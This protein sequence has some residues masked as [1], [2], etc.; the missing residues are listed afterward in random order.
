MCECFSGKYKELEACKEEAA[1]GSELARLDARL[2][3]LEA[4]KKAAVEAGDYEAA[5]RHQAGIRWV[6]EQRQALVASDERA[7]RLE[8]RIQDLRTRE[9]AAR[10]ARDYPAAARRQAGAALL[11]A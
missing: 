2:R 7:V 4:T 10:E 6:Y 3:V 5:A 9:A 11:E 8:E 1:Q